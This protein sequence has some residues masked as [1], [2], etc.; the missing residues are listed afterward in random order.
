[1]TEL[2]PHGHAAHAGPLA[3][4][5]ILVVDDEEDI[6]TFLLAVFA[7]AGAEIAEAADGTEALAVATALHPELVTLDLSMPGHDGIDVFC[8]LRR[9][10]ATAD[11]AICIVTGHPEFR[12]V[13]Y[14]RAEAPPDGFMTKPVEPAELVRT[15][16]RILGLADRRAA[17]TVDTHRA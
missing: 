6:R 11:I 5:R 14:D 17:R 8:E 12:R 13:I 9:T 10:P 7:D 2:E 15:A 1:M 4:R 3:G 16:R